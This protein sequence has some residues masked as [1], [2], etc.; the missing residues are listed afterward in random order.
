MKQL[1]M[2]TMRSE[3]GKLTLDKT[4]EE[5]ESLN[6]NIVRS[7]NESSDEWGIH[8]MRYEIKDIVPPTNIRK[9][10]ELQAESER[11]K[12]ADI[13]TSEG[14][15]QAEI[16]IAEGHR[17]AAILSAEGEA[18]AIIA[19]ADATAEGIKILAEAI[20]TQGGESA[21]KLRVAEQYVGAFKEMARTNNTMIIPA[22]PN[23]IAS[24]VS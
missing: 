20:E 3:L 12:R 9:A 13:L 17:S 6:A 2:T 16:N 5:R 23:N 11:Q 18:K 10:M 1:A 4:F 8:C 22:E 7:I 19:K 24:I 14:R 15:R 21:V